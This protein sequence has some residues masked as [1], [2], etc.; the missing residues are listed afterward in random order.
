M[1]FRFYKKDTFPGKLPRGERERER[2]GG[3]E[4]KTERE[5]EFS[6]QIFWDFKVKFVTYRI[7]CGLMR[8]M[9]EILP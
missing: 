1:Q 9:R 8:N 5:L 3:K 7:L 2:E 6:F 4:R